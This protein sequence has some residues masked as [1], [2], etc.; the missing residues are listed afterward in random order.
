MTSSQIV[1]R[2]HAIVY[3]RILI[4]YGIALLL[5]AALYLF[6]S[7]LSPRSIPSVVPLLT[8]GL[9]AVVA[10]F[11]L[12]SWMDERRFSWTVADEVLELRTGWLPWRTRYFSIEYETIFESYYTDGLL[13]QMLHYGTCVIRRTEGVTSKTEEPY[14]SNV[15][16]L[17]RAI[18]AKVKERREMLR[19]PMMVA[20]GATAV[21]LQSKSIAEQIRELAL[22]KADG[23]I[24]QEEFETVKRS[25]LQSGVSA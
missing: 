23:T 8:L 4:G 24:T 12:L 22:L 15:K 1:G 7:S 14:V 13:G 16:T 21:P 17:V 18:N 3:V 19:Q 25:I 5:L 9:I 20:A 2:K 6:L 10:F 11:G